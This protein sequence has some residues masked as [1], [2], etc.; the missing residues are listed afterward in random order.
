M[1][2]QADI[3]LQAMTLIS[4]LGSVSLA[5]TK[6]FERKGKKRKSVC[7]KVSWREPLSTEAAPGKPR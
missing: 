5:G 7:R 4:T 6:L 2:V 3:K 1:H